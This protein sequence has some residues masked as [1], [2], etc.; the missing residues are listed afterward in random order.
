MPDTPVNDLKSCEAWLARAALAD[1]RHA[2]MTLTSLLETLQDKP[3]A[4]GD[5]LEVLERL[6]EPVVVA[7][8]ERSKKFSARPLRLSDAEREAFE[9]VLDLWRSLGAAYRHLLTGIGEAPNAHPQLR[10][11]EALLA[12]RGLDCVVDLMLSHYRCRAELDPELWQDLHRLYRIVAASG[13]ARETVP[14]GRKSKSVSSPAEVYSRALLLALAN[15][16]TLSVRE[17]TW[18]RRWSAKWAYKVKFSEGGQDCFAVDPESG[19]PPAWHAQAPKKLIAMETSDIRRSIRSRLKKIEAGEDPESL[20]LGNDCVLPDCARLLQTLAKSWTE[21][22]TARQFSRRPTPGVAEL[23]TGF[24]AIHVG[25]TQRVFK[26]Q[27]QQYSYTRKHQTEEL[28]SY[29]GAA[30]EQSSA[31]ATLTTERWEILDESAIGFRLRRTGP[32]ERISQHQ[33]VALRPEDGRAFILCDVRWL[34]TGVD[35][36][37]IVGLAVL[38]GVAQGVASRPVAGPNEAAHPYTQSFI[39]PGVGDTVAS[40]ITPIGYFQPGRTVELR[41][42]ESLKRARLLEQL[43]RGYDFERSSFEFIN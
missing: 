31:T 41:I 13:H 40:L 6:R 3:P 8:A 2:C 29:H 7:L 20:G 42:E 12:Q 35:Q 32:G 23:S 14:V 5:Y 28:Y 21:Q 27:P 10:G 25:I 11:K 38:P 43:Q 39:L 34:M 36:S 30:R 1:P 4:D 18:A 9:Q 24:E 26:D 33:L 15:P 17:L 37:L 19:A 22:P 16:Y